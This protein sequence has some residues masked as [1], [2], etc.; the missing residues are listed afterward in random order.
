MTDIKQRIDFLTEELN[1]HGRLYYEADAPEITDLEYDKM[2]E[3]LTALEKEMPLLRREDSPTNRVGGAPLKQFESVVHRVPVI[4]LDNS[5]SREELLDFDRRTRNAVSLALGEEAAKGLSYVVEPKIDGLSVVLQYREGLFVRGATRGDGE[6]GEDITT[7]L[8]T[9]R[10][11]PYRI[12]EKE[13]L[14]VRGEVYI[15]KK[16][17][18]ELNR[19]QEIRGGQIFA[20]PRNAAAGSL[21]QLDPK[22][23]AE[24]SLSIFVFNIQYFKSPGQM[25]EG[26][27]THGEN[28]E[29]LKGMGFSVT[30]NVVCTN[31]EEV[32]AQCVVWEERRSSLPYDIDGLVVK[33]NQLSFRDALGFRAKSPRWAMAYKFKAEEQETRILDIVVQVG[34]TGVITPKAVFEPVRVAGSVVTYATLH[35]EDYIKEKDL[36]IGD[37]VIVHK[38]GDVIPEVVRA[39]HEERKGEER[40]FSMPRF[41]PSCGTVLLRQEGEAALRCPNHK[42]CPA[43]NLRGI[44]HFVA[45]G[46]MDIEGLGE[47]LVER[48]SDA[49]LISSVADIYR[50]NREELM[51]L[52]GLGEKSADNLLRAIEES[53]KK[54]L[55]RLLFGLGIPL[56]GSKAAKLLARNFGSLD[57][58]FQASKETLTAIDEI[59]EKMAESLLSYIS[60]ERNRALVEEL[61]QA[62]LN[63][64]TEEKKSGGA[65]DEEAGGLFS[66][67]TFV[68][69][70][71]LEHYTREEAQEIIENLGGKASGSVSKK[72]DYVL[73]GREAGSKLQ[74]A[75]SLGVKILSEEEFREMLSRRGS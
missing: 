25:P 28:L 7:N 52:E 24:R 46:A 10:S 75:E 26:I 53:K 68:L 35:N 11:V 51:V 60:D 4:S 39:I 5:Y 23:T 74:K 45:R 65:K 21:R 50:L 31:I 17:F 16:D 38:A 22:V 6:T 54:E 33:V 47:S 64:R 15:P 66:G 49:G 57:A 72:T 2:M 12:S 37:R 20:N 41:C 40:V 58:L 73:A 43:Q 56:I 14:D 55:W 34:R 67:K 8:R 71:T 59:G 9:L 32:L 18:L 27:L 63:M 42:G 19:R 62:G 1:R 61:R 13:E 3:E 36:R 69:T 48:L 70:G 29:Y 30:E 44:R